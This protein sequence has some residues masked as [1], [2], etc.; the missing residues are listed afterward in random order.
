MKIWR[1]C[2]AL[3]VWGGV[4][5]QLWLM[6]HGKAG[7]E[8]GQAVVRFFSFFTILSNL[9]VGV[10]LS[11]SVLA[12]ATPLG[13]WAARAGTRVAVAVYI[14][15]TA[16][17]YHT[18]LAGLWNPQGAQLVADTLLHSVT[19]ALYLLDFLIAPPREAARWSTAWKALVFPAVYGAWSLLHGAFSGFYPYPFLDVAKHGYGAVLVNMLAMAAGFYVVT[20]V[21]TG[22]QHLQLRLAPSARRPIS[23]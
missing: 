21:M 2:A 23:A 17:I 18:L 19:P 20:L 5:L 6:I 10:L 8:L 12:A 4:V 9:A 13:R 1:A 22:L 15:V 3:I 7:P 11:A 16:A 14:A